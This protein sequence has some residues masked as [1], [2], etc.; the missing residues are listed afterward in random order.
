MESTLSIETFQENI[1][2]HFNQ[3]DLLQQALTHRSYVNENYD[4]DDNERLEYLGD[5]I[6]GYIVAD[7][8]YRQ[9]PG[10]PEGEMTRL[11][12][13]LV[14]TES[15][16]QL[17][18]DCRVGEAFIMGKGESAG[19]GRE[20]LSNLCGAFEAIIG[21]MHIDQ[22]LQVVTDFV[23]PRLTALQKEVM[24]EALRKD[25]RSRFQEWVQAKYNITPHFTIVDTFGLEHEKIF[26]AHAFVGEQF[27]C[28]GQG[29]NKRA[30]AQDAARA[31]LD[32]RDQGDM[33]IVVPPPSADPTQE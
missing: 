24:E 25:P 19:G 2:V 28:E 26:V 15:L 3:P 30:A 17:A 5:A 22:G 8:L 10:M 33:K 12:S 27:I 11:R 21:A 9:Y 20:N 23:M 4:A 1:N 18:I 16:A 32:K 14:R 29:K 13:A 31:A 6:L 7:M